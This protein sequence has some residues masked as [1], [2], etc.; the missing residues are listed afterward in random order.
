MKGTVLTARSSEQGG[1]WDYFNNTYVKLDIVS[2]YKEHFVLV[3][4]SCR[5][6]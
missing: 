5:V 2:K 3:K 4:L 1:S 6:L